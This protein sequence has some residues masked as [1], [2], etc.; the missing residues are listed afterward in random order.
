MKKFLNSLLDL[1]YRKKCYFCG[2]SKYSL[3]MCPEC[4]EKL[5]FNEF[6]AN[7][8]YTIYIVGNKPNIEIIQSVD[9]NTYACM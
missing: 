3:K 2:K 8:I 5:D 9:G 6:K 4:Y 1:I 7:R